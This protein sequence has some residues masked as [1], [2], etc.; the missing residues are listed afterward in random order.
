[1]PEKNPLMASTTPLTLFFAASIGV[2]IADFIPFQTE[3]AVLLMLLNTEDTVLFTALNTV[4]TVFLIA[5]T[6][7]VTD[8]FTPFHTVAAVFLMAL[9]L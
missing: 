1:M 5:F 9:I 3:V 7:V 6:G 2:M 4:L 8:V